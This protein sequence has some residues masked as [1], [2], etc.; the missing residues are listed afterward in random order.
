M[1]NEAPKEQKPYEVKDMP[2]EEQPWWF[3]EAE[4]DG[5][6]YGQLYNW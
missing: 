5:F 6:A 4:D 2:E 3:R 1:T